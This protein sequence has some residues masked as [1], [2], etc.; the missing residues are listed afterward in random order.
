ATS[1]RTW[2]CSRLPW[3]GHQYH[4][5]HALVGALLV[6][7]HHV[8][9]QGMLQCTLPEQDQSRERFL[10][11]RAHPA[12]GVGIQIRRAWWEWHPRDACLINNALKG[13]TVLTVFV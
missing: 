3:C 7:M 11:D 8:L 1:E 2:A 13:W 4:I 10:F 9:R 12:L 5:A 6:K